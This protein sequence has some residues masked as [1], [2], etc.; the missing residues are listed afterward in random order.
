MIITFLEIPAI[1]LGW[2]MDCPVSLASYDESE[3]ID[4]NVY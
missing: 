3:T 4:V 2:H 1:E